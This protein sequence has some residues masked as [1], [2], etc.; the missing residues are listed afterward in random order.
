LSQAVA[1]DP[2]YAK[3][4][5]Y[6]AYSYI[7]L[8]TIFGAE[9][10]AL[11]GLEK[12]K[13][14]IDKALELD[15]NLDVAHMLLGFYSLYHDW[16]FEKAEAEYKL[17]V[18]NEDPDALAMYIDY[19]NFVRRHDEAMK[20]S[21][22]L[23]EVDPYYPNSRMILSYFYTNQLDKAI[24][25]SES[26]I[27]MYNNYYTLDSYGFLMLNSGHYKEAIEYFNKAIALEG[28]R[29]P[30][31]LGWMG[32]AYAKD[33]DRANALKIIDEFKSRLANNDKASI[34]FFIAAIYAAL[35]D[36]QS[37]LQW[38]QKAYEAHDMEMPWLLTEPQFYSLHD[39]PAFQEL[40]KKIG[41]N[42][43]SSN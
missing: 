21:E 24:A 12:G 4:N 35:K 3:A 25:F 11:E 34:S 22:Q 5:A 28:I 19:L 2:N 39:E 13:P 42:Q 17:A 14:F 7:G 37:A 9:L 43:S 40:A 10:G 18:V 31:M 23:N 20:L 30:R 38:L 15:P 26:R 41:F 33:G 8:S 32:A 16:D 29:Y 6:L 1:L 27:K 36:K